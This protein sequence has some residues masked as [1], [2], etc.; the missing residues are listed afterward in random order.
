MPLADGQLLDRA[1][2][3]ASCAA[4]CASASGAAPA[5]DYARAPHR[6]AIDGR[7]ATFLAADTMCELRSATVALQAAED[8]GRRRARRSRAANAPRSCSPAASPGPSGTSDAVERRFTRRSPSGVV[9]RPEPLSRPLARGRRPLGDHAQAADLRP[10]GAVVAAPTT[11]LPEHIGGPRNWDYRYCW[12]RDSAIH[13]VRVPAPRLPRGGVRLHDAGCTGAATCGPTA[14]P[15][16]D[17]HA[18][19]AQ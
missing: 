19:R 2:H 13:D 3:R 4:P 16:G 15:A 14:R 10:T 17:V 7:L 11:S 5:F 12:L 9:D 6:L 18:R 1:P 8:S